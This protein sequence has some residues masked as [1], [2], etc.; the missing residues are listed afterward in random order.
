MEFPENL[1]LIVK[2]ISIYGEGELSYQDEYDINDNHFLHG[3]NDEISFMH[4][5][6]NILV[7]S[8]FG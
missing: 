6:S 5:N 4:K 1:N 8:I 7:K 2:I 3:S